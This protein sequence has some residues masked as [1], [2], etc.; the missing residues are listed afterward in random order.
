MIRGNES[1]GLRYYRERDKVGDYVSVDW[2]T[3]DYYRR[4]GRNHVEARATAIHGEVS[5]VCTT[6]VSLGWLRNRCRRVRKADIP[7][8]WLAV[9]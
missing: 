3:L 9:L 6:G 4:I 2:S 7:A 5:S 1:D 8:N